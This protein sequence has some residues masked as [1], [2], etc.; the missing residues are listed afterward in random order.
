MDT[1]D[2][3]SA[4]TALTTV[5]KSSPGAPKTNS[6]S[7]P[8]LNT[9]IRIV[10]AVTTVAENRKPPTTQSE[11]AIVVLFF[12]KIMSYFLSF[13]ESRLLQRNFSRTTQAPTPSPLRIHTIAWDPRSVWPNRITLTVAKSNTS[14]APVTAVI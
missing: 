1:V 4:A 5:P 13:A 10:S 9:P 2:E 6:P 8:A 11:I 7:C 3:P 12:F 14:A